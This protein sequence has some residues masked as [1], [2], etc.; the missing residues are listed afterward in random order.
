MQAIDIVLSVECW[1]RNSQGPNGLRLEHLDQTEQWLLCRALRKSLM[2]GA[3]RP[4]ESHK[5][6]IPKDGEP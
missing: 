4:G 6:K 5:V 2:E 1:R 3:Y